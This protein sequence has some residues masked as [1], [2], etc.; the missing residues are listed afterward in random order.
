MLYVAQFDSNGYYVE[1]S[2]QYNE[3]LPHGCVNLTKELQDLI[4]EFEG[5][6]EGDPKFVIKKEDEESYIK[7]E[8]HKG[9]KYFLPEDT[10]ESPEREMKEY[11]PFPEGA[12]FT[13]PTPPAEEL[14]RRVRAERDHK[15]STTDWTQVADV[16]A[17]IGE[18]KVKEYVVYRQDLRDITD[19][20]GFP[21]DGENVP[22]PVE[23]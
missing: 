22:W 4:D 18:E 12:T 10:W 5:L 17:V 13:R 7:V 19:E 2:T 11:G 1:K 6:Q 23:P 14:A 9:E 20:E 21:W 8:N 16:K 3:A 15:L